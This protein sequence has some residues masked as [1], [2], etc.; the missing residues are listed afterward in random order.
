ME[1]I[2]CHQHLPCHPYLEMCGTCTF[3]EAD[4]MMEF[5]GTWEEVE[6]A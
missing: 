6:D 3:G 2:V 1:C 4:A 5:D